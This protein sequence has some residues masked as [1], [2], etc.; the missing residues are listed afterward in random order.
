MN[1]FFLGFL[2]L[3]E[4]KRLILVVLVQGLSLKV[5]SLD[6]GLPALGEL[7]EL[8]VGTLIC[9]NPVQDI[10]HIYQGELLRTCTDANKQQHCCN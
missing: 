5:Q 8:L 4:E 1:L 3:G 9:R 10:F 7:I 2:L 6:L